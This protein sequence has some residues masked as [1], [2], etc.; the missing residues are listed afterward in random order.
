MMPLRRGAL[1]CG[2]EWHH[3]P[4]ALV[5]YAGAGKTTLGR[6]LA[7]QLGRP[8]VDLDELVA[9][10]AG[11]PIAALFAQ[12]GEAAFRALEA[13]VLAAALDHDRATGETPVYALG[14]GT[15]C[16][17]ANLERLLDA[18]Y[19]IFLDVPAAEL[20]RRLAP[21]RAHRPRLAGVE[22]LE[23]FVAADLAARRPAYAHAHRTVAGNALTLNDLLAA[24]GP[25]PG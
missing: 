7:A 13:Q 4:L 3:L 6:P 22:D 11:Q 17:P 10:T 1:S 21:Q 16:Q 23:A 24:L 9:G 5:G 14:G 18:A 25:L 19:L 8:F 12:H 15:P 20:A 2:M